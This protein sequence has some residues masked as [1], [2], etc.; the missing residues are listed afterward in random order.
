MCLN[1]Y[2]LVMISYLLQVLILQEEW[3][4]CLGDIHTS[5]LICINGVKMTGIFK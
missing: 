5:S 3:K 2:H 4:L 1:D